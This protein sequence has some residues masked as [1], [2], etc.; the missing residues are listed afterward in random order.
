MNDIRVVQGDDLRVFI[1][2]RDNAG[3]PVDLTGAT[4]IRWALARTFGDPILLEKTLAAATI[5][6]TGDNAFFFDITAAESGALSP[7]N[8]KQEAEIVTAGG[9]RYTTVQSN[10][11][12]LPQL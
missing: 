12:V 8:Y 2:V 4:E 10:F 1:S 9:L 11:A 6:L 5:S 7:A 3:D